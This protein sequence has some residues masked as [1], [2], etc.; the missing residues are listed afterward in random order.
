M[1]EYKIMTYPSIGSEKIEKLNEYGA[2]GW[3]YVRHEGITSDSRMHNR[4]LFIR[5]KLDETI[6]MLMNKELF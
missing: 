5:I 6:K 2:E 4:A 1:Y 3:Q